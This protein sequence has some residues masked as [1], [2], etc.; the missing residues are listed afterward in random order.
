MLTS[1]VEAMLNLVNSA[2]VLAEVAGYREG[3]AL[4]SKLPPRYHSPEVR[5]AVVLVLAGV[6]SR[7]PIL[8]CVLRT[9]VNSKSN[10]TC[11]MFSN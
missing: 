7:T 1:I 10:G 11:R 2:F 8:Q 4:P 9:S 6:P 3:Y 5:P